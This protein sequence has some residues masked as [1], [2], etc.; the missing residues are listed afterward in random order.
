MNNLF[1]YGTL[2]Y[3]DKNPTYGIEMKK[4]LEK[5]VHGKV[6]GT[7]YVVEGFPFLTLDGDDWVDGKLFK[8][9][10]LEHLLKKYDR[11]EGA[12]KVDPFFERV[13]VKVR[14]DDGNEEEAYC[15]IGGSGLEKSFAKPEYRVK[16][17]DWN[18]VK[19]N[20]E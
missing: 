7:L 8:F 10:E 14:L 2:L 1:T 12:D 20:W 13:N 9:K 6:K 18:K 11:I 19:D 4:Y 15:Y 17:E 16:S 3:E 5:G